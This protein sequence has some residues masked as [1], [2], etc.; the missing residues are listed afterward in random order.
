MSAAVRFLLRAALGACALTAAAAAHAQQRWDMS[1]AWPAGNFHSRNA[2]AFAAKVREATDGQVLITVHAGGELN[3]KGPDT[4]M[5]VE[6][7]IVQV[8][9][10][11]VSQQAGVE[12]LLGMDALPGLIAGQDDMKTFLRHARPVYDRIAAAHNQRILY[13]VPWPSPG[14]FSRK[15]LSTPEDMKGQKLRAHDKAA[16]EFMAQ[17]GAA[18]TQMPWGEVV[19]AL[20]AGTIDGV[21]T[22]ASSGVDGKFWEFTPHFLPLNWATSLSLVTVNLDA[23]DKLSAA[24]QQAV[25][26]AAAELEPRFWQISAAQDEKDLAIL[27]EHKVA[28]ATPSEALSARVAAV[29]RPMW[30][31]FARQAGPQARQLLDAYLQDRKQP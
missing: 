19:P 15:A 4:L 7:G 5:A 30:D 8:A 2:E 29:G 13:A 12:P 9:D 14:L 3:V 25:Q 28:I 22:S 17:L 21:G 26:A 18:P 10:M 11:L 20:A 31:A 1:L 24:Q 23:W 6:S 16:Y 27:R